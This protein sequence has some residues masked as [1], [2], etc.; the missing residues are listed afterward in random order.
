MLS[1]RCTKVETQVR[2]SEIEGHRHEK[3]ILLKIARSQKVP[4]AFLFVGPQGIGKKAVALAFYS[5]LVCQNKTDEDSCGECRNCRQVDQGIFADLTVISPEKGIIRIDT[6]KESF[7][8]LFYEPIVGPWKCIIIDD[9]HTMR[10]EA[11]NA[12][13][14][15]IEEPPPSS[16]FILVTSMPDLLPQ[17]ILSRCLRLNFSPVSLEGVMRTLRKHYP[18]SE[19]DIRI[20]SHFSMGSPGKAKTVMESQTY[21]ERVEFISEFLSLKD[22]DISRCLEF[23][24]SIAM[25]RESQGELMEILGSVIRDA[26]LLSVGYMGDRLLNPDFARSIK[27]FSDHIGIDRLLDLADAFLEYDINL[28]Y[29]PNIRSAIDKM[30]T[31][32]P[33]KQMG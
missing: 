30:M 29:S 10:I 20:V 1:N 6:I 14:K 7:P 24:D 21:R 31:M 4:H 9:A 17:T 19:Q 13:L 5:Y 18:I 22:A 23:A 16:L 33:L 11:A 2:F 3:Q 27:E 25:N 12:A 32:L 28:V 15:T 26:L 8:R